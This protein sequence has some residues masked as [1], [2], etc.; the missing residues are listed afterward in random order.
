MLRS[1]GTVAAGPDVPELEPQAA[2]RIAKTPELAARVRRRNRAN[3]I[4]GPPV[5]GCSGSLLSSS[6]LNGAR[7]R[8]QQAYSDPCASGSSGRARLSIAQAVEFVKVAIVQARR[9]VRAL[10]KSLWSGMIP[11]RVS[12]MGEGTLAWLRDRNRARV[13]SA[14]RE[15]GRLSQAEIARATG[16]SRTTVHSLVAELK[17]DGVVAELGGATDERAAGRP[18]VRLVLRDAERAVLGIDF[19]HSHVQVAV[20]DMSRNIVAEGRCDLDV[21]HRALEA[22]D[23]ATR[24]AGEQLARA[25]VERGSAQERQVERRS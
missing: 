24:M 9:F 22:L 12:R 7:V 6:R 18:G 2:T 3:L 15:R 13:L 14:L 25:R 4:Y 16:L 8:R 21:N 11:V 5:H 10:D 20:A 23:T 1:E 17:A 19:G